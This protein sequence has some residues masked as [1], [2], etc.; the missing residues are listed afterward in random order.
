MCSMSD[1]SYTYFLKQKPIP[2]LTPYN[3]EALLNEHYIHYSTVKI[4]NCMQA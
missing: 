4:K 1:E 3:T 2:P